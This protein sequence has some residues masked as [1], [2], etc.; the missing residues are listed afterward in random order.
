MNIWH[1]LH[2]LFDK[3]DG[4]LPD[5]FIN[6]IS[7]EES[8]EIYCWVLSLTTIFGDPTL[9]STEEERDIKIKDIANPALYYTEGKAESFRHGLEIFSINGVQIPQL[10]IG[11]GE[12]YVEFDYRKGNEWGEKELVALFAFLQHITCMAPAAKIIHAFEGS[13]DDPNNEF[14]EIFGEYLTKFTCSKCSLAD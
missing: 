13:H 10:T 3:D 12:S 4:S 11:V 6:D 8:V 14:T 2:H 5:I 9:W 1:N 7:P